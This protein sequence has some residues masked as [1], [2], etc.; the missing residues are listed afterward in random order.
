M[1]VAWASLAVLTAISVTFFVYLGT[2]IDALGVKID[3]EGGELRTAIDS[4]AARLD[5]RIDSLAQ[6]FD[7]HVTGERPAG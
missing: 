2:K 6:R 7:A 4:L 1:A 5:A 3:S